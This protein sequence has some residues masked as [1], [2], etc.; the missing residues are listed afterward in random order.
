[1]GRPFA[2]FG[3][4]P[5][6]L[7]EEPGGVGELLPLIPEPFAPAPPEEAAPLPGFGI[8]LCPPPGTG[9]CP[10]PEGDCWLPGREICPEFCEPEGRPEDGLKEPPA[11]PLMLFV[12]FWHTPSLLKV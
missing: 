6:W 2:P 8:W 4:E 3:R 1:M 11:A 12:S 9:D 5:P 10:L 7:P